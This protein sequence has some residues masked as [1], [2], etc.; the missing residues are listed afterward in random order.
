MENI[1]IIDS[2]RTPM[3]RS[4]G[5]AFRQVRA[6]EL[7]AH[8]MTQ[9]LSRNPALNSNKNDIDDIIWGCVQQTLEQGFN[10][11]RNAALL[12]DIPHTVPAVTVNRLCGSSMQALHDAARFI[13]SGDANV[14]LVGGVEHMGHV[15][16]TH[17]IDLNSKIAVHVSTASASM[18]LTAE[19]LA[20]QC[21][22]SRVEQDEFALRSHQRAAEATK[23][24][25]FN[26]EI[27]ATVGHDIDGNLVAIKQDEVIRFDANLASLAALPPVFDP[28]SGSITA[29][30]SSAL[31]DGASAIVVTSEKYAKT[32][33]LRIRAKIRSMSVI[34]CDPAIMGYGPVPA[35]T[36][37]L[38]RAKLTLQ[39]IDVFEINEAFAAQAL[40]CLKDLRLIDKMEEKVNLHGG[41]IA[42]GHPLGC[43]GARI[44]TSLLNIME[45]KDAQFGLATMCIGFGQGIA[46]LIERIK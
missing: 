17:G 4:K 9:L 34:G 12:T 37:A 7:S 42:L 21:Q 3:G 32:R 46:T 6:E 31:S 41:A 1:V 44:I 45:R 29:G 16:M 2:I 10:I 27:V 35:T 30:N 26:D 28:T 39:D 14:V 40:A 8:L 15:P 13:K 18:G 5:G 24:G 33:E 20:R 22:I 19:M 25:W 43:S 11:A 38:K 36:M 23:Q